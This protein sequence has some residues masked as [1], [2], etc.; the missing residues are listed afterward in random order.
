MNSK[1]GRE[2]T[3]EERKEKEALAEK[4]VELVK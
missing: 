1:K 4:A 3:A 2:R